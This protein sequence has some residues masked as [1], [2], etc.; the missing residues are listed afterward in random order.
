MSHQEMVGN[1]V[2]S[3]SLKQ[4]GVAQN[5]EGKGQEAEGQLKDL[6]AG[7]KDRVGGAVGGAIAG[8]T[9]D[10]EGQAAAQKQHDDGKARQRGVE[11]ELQKEADAQAK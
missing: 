11:A 1:L 3:E 10:R 9:G 4:E 8:I 7:V 2:G 6:G 5:R